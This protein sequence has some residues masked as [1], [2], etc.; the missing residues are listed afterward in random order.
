M[1]SAAGAAVHALNDGFGETAVDYRGEAV[2]ASLGENQK[3]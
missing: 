3:K 1:H 2:V